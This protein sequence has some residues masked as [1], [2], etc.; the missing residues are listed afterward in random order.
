M[1][2]QFIGKDCI[3]SLLCWCTAFFDY[4]GDSVSEPWNES[5]STIGHKIMSWMVKRALKKA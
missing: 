5:L 1:Y 4:G 3:L 2:V